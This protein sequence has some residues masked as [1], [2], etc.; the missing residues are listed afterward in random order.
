VFTVKDDC[1]FLQVSLT[2][3]REARL[4][5]QEEERRAKEEKQNTFDAKIG[6]A[7]VH[8]ETDIACRIMRF[9]EELITAVPDDDNLIHLKKGT[10]KLTFVSIENEQDNY[11][12]V[13][14]VKDE[15]EFL[16]VSLTKIRDTR[17]AKEEEEAEAERKRIAED[18]ARYLKFEKDG[19]YG[20]KKDGVVVIPFKYDYAW[21][22]SEGL[23][24]VELDGKHGYIDK[25]GKEVIP[26]KYDIAWG[27]I[28][29]L[30]RVKLN[31]KYGFIDRG[32]KEVI[33][34]KYDDAWDFQNGKARV[35]LD[36]MR[37]YIDKQGNF[38]P[39]K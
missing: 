20:F 21:S 2:K 25:A 39:D 17:L 11:S 36:G 34:I 6:A 9:K 8:I 27:F 13:Y 18:D 4:A 16:Q 15:C 7:E 10:H 32:G 26:F 29:G 5:K 1:E 14:I 19:K 12:Q 31:R 28:D 22:F 3:I 30:A 37:G 35:R 33:P 23:A 38:T 24:E